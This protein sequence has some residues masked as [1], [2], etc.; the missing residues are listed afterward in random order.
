MHFEPAA[1]WIA[2]DEPDRV[3]VDERYKSIASK[4]G[5]LLSGNLNLPCPS[6]F[7]L[8]ACHVA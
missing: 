4:R 8:A 5:S 2:A 3:D 7:V 6:L 1:A